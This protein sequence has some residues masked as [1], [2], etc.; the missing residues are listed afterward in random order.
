VVF[1]ADGRVVGG[2]ATPSA[3]RIL[4]AMKGLAP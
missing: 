4:D 3:E 2:L 1:L